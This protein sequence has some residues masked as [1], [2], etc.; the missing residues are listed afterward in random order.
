VREKGERKR[1]LIDRVERGWLQRV[2]IGHGRVLCMDEY[3]F[4][5]VVLFFG[6]G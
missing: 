6:M 4:S 1:E 2:Y 5:C 3:L